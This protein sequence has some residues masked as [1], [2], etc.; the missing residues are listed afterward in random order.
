MHTIR[1]PKRFV[2]KAEFSSNDKVLCVVETRGCDDEDEHA[3]VTGEVDAVWTWEF[4]ERGDLTM[5]SH[6]G[7]VFP[8]RSQG[9]FE[10]RLRTKQDGTVL[11]ISGRDVAIARFP[12]KLR[13]MSVHSSGRTWAC[14]VVNYLCLVTL[15]NARLQAPP[16]AAQRRVTR[17]KLM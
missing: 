9:G 11:E 14:G 12:E 2:W 6:R 7:E 10:H 13:L 4:A 8:A 16:R 17:R 15:E 5:W 1:I 3:T